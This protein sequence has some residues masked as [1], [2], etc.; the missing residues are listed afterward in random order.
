[1]AHKVTRDIRVIL[2][3]RAHKVTRDMPVTLADTARKV[4]LVIQVR[5][6]HMARKVLPVTLVTRQELK[7]HK[8]LLATPEIMGHKVQ[9]VTRVAPAPKDLRGIPAQQV[10]TDHKDLPDTKVTPQDR[11]DHKVLPGI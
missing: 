10:Y 1:M 9:R 2:A 6:V 5:Q 8:A 7:D 11:K 4:L 3:D